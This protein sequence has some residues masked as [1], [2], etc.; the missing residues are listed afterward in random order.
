M[1]YMAGREAIPAVPT[2][3]TVSADAGDDTARIQTAI[4]QV[5]ANSDAEDEDHHHIHLQQQPVISAAERAEQ[6]VKFKQLILNLDSGCDTV[7]RAKASADIL[8]VGWMNILG[9]ADIHSTGHT[10]IWDFS[11]G[12]VLPLPK[13]R[14][15]NLTSSVRWE[16]SNITNKH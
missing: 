2:V 15:T 12:L 3:V 16:A 5:A 9:I 7:V 11:Q 6:Q 14:Q 1:G 4:N 13:T 8:F 10:D